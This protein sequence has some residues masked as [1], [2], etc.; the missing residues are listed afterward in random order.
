MKQFREL[1]PIVT[2]DNNITLH[3]FRRFKTSHLLNLRFL[4]AEIAEIDSKIYQAGLASGHEPSARDRLGLKHSTIEPDAPALEDTI[5]RDLI[6]R[7]RDLLSQYGLCYP[8]HPGHLTINVLTSRLDAALTSFSQVMNMETISL[9]DDE[10][11][12]NM[13]TGLNLFEKYKARLV[14]VDLGTRARTDPFERWLHKKL[15]D[16]RYWRI[17]LKQDSSLSFLSL[18]AD[19]W[20]YQNTV[21]IASVLGRIFT[22][23]IIGLF[24]IAPLAILTV[25]PI[26]GGQVAVVCGCIALFSAVTGAL[27]RVSSYEMMAASAAYAAVLSVFVSNA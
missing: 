25:V 22:T 13:N 24:L 27:L 11:Q 15:R 12:S 1:W 3:S 4:E 18:S 7:L 16:L 9:L 23:L 5:T 6:L 10:K 14:R 19:H 17:T 8:R 20:S 21:F 26:K 2:D